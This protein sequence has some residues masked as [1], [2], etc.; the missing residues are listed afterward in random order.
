M[1]EDRHQWRRLIL[2]PTPGVGKLGTLNED[3]RKERFCSS[4]LK[5]A[6]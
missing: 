5:H 1:A 4:H 2:R 3:D 6:K